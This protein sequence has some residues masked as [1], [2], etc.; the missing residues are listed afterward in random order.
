MREKLRIRYG[1]VSLS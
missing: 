1:G